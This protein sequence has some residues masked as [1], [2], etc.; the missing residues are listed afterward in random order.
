M[1]FYNHQH[2]YDCGIGRHVKT[3]YLCILDATGQVLVHRNVPS[4]PAAFLE[5]VG[6]YRTD[7][8]VAAECMF[9]W[10]GLA[11]LCAADGLTFV[12]GHALAMKAIHGGKAKNDN[13]DSHQI[14][15]LLRGGLLPQADV[16]PAGMRSTRDRLRRRLPLVRKRGPL[17]AHI[18]NTRAQYH[19]PECGRRLASPGNRDGVVDHVP[20]PRVHTSIEVDGT[21]IDHDEALVT[22]L[23]LT[24]VREAKRHDGDAFHRLIGVR[25]SWLT[26]S[27]RPQTSV[28]SE[29]AA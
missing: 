15:V 3:R 16:Y 12:L 22:D 9:T 4:T 29:T 17:L 5:V 2:P 13:I 6:P 26:A 1:R 27:L 8:V 18:Q 21:L 20:D 24:I 28:I 14:A 25:L 23:A 19:L 7:L 10:Y 11:D